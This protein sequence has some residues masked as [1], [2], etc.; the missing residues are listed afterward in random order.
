M[1]YIGGIMGLFSSLVSL[2]DKVIILER[3]LSREKIFLDKD[4]KKFL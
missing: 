2:Q 3:M 4:L 1:Y